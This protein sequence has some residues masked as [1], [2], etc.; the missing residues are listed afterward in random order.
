MK[1]ALASIGLLTVIV[2]FSL[3]ALD[4]KNVVWESGK[5]HCPHCRS[6]VN[7]YASVCNTCNR[8]FDWDTWELDCVA[9]L[10][11]LDAAYHLATH[12]A[13]PD[14]AA[15]RVM[16][17]VG[18]KEDVFPDVEEYLDE[19]ESGACGFCAGT[20]RWLLADF[21]GKPEA[22]GDDNPRLVILKKEI[23]GKCP[24]CLGTG[25]CILC[26]GDH[27]VENGREASDMAFAEFVRQDSGLSPDR[28]EKSMQAWIRAVKRF[29]SRYMGQTEVSHMPALYRKG[30]SQISWAEER[31]KTITNALH[32]SD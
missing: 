4:Q 1:W 26:D 8:A 32:A 21:G 22:W 17:S 6:V 25:R 12:Q 31:L 9:C 18:F 30:A 20:G 15:R 2:V 23:N 27:R 16:R 11:K 14:A 13:D 24:V 28:D 7:D 19:I 10:S 5:A 3:A 29:L